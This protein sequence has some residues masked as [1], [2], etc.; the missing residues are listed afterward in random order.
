MPGKMEFSNSNIKK[1]LYFRE[2]KPLKNFLSF[3]KRKLFLIFPK[4]ET[5]KNFLYSRKQNF[6]IFQ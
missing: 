1:V 2:Q 4:M 5:L 3:L 6:F